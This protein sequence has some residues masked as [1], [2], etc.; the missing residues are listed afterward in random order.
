MDVTKAVDQARYSD[1]L[2]SLLN[3]LEAVKILSVAYESDYQGFVDIDALLK[4]GRVF[5]YKYWY[6]S[7]SGC[8]DWE[9]RNLSDDAIEEEMLREATIFDNVEQY[10]EWRNKVN[11]RNE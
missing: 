4:D 11:D 7:C 2:E 8:D 6:G 5:S 3:K 1:N 10:L 9:Y